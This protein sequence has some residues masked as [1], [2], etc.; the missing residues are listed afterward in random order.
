MGE[1]ILPQGYQGEGKG[2]PEAKI[3]SGELIYPVY[4]G[5]GKWLERKGIST[6]K[7]ASLDE[8]EQEVLTSEFE[9]EKNRENLIRYGQTL[10]Y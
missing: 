3:R 7:Y 1:R 8:A 9:E 6:E 2:A 10:T 4:D 5:F